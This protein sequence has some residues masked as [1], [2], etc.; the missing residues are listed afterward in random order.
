MTDLPASWRPTDTKPVSLA[1][2][3]AGLANSWPDTDQLVS[4]LAFDSRR[5]GQGCLYFGLPGQ[6]SHGA[7][8]AVQAFAN[9]ALAMVTDQAGLALAPAGS[10]VVVV[11]QPRLAMAQAAVRLF[12][13]PSATRLTFGLTGTVGKTTTCLMLDAAL[14]AQGRHPG[15]VGSVG[16]ALDGVFLPMRRSTPTT[17]ESVD[18]QALLAAMAQRGADCFVME[19]TS[20]GLDLDRLAGVGFDVVGFTNLGRDHLDYHGTVEA[21]FQAKA[22]LFKPGWASQAVVNIDDEHGRRLVDMICDA[23]APPVTTVGRSRDADWR[24]VGGGWYGASQQVV[25]EHD[26]EMG[27]F[28]LDMPGDFNASNG[29][30][31]MA[32]MDAAG[33]D[34]TATAEGLTH[35]TAAGR[36]QRVDLGPGAPDVIVD[37]AHT[38]DAVEAALRA[39]PSPVIAVVGCGGDRDHGKR[40]ITGAVAASNCDVLIVTDD[41]P[42]TEDPAAIRSAICRGATGHQAAVLDIAPRPLAIKQA[43]AL[44]KPGWTVM[45]LGRGAEAFQEVGT[46]LLPLY[47]PDVAKA[48]WQELVE[49]H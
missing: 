32:M 8:F 49:G 22:R 15:Y 16:F 18:L 26:G 25:Y 28:D 9:G 27:Q 19:A 13:D 41:N 39:V 10:P 31:A 38:P 20:I 45:V 4:D 48:A 44:A 33:L 43:L 2:L 23:G 12:G 11:E 36:M 34:R 17:P 40:E 42:R 24:I 3:L 35:A 37:F 21:Y 6:K 14:R 1:W 47:D 29:L 7:Q 46:S 30:L 5:V